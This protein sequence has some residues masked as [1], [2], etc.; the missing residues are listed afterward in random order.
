MANHSSIL[1]WRI[2][3]MEEPSELQTMGSQGVRHNSV[4]NIHTQCK[5][6]HIIY[7]RAASCFLLLKFNNEVLR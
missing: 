2:P 1:A 3:L 6:K 7:D 5:M 4:S